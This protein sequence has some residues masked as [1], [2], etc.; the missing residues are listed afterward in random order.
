MK[1]YEISN[2]YVEKL[3]NLSDNDDDAIHEQMDSIA[4]QFAD[5]AHEIGKIIR[6]WESDV[7]E[8]RDEI[9]RLQRKRAA[10][11]NR[12][13]SL[14]DYL[15]FNMERTGT[16]IIDNNAITI[17]VHQSPPSLNILNP[18]NVPL[19]Y[20]KIETKVDKAGLKQAIQNGEIDDY[21]QYCQL[22]HSKN[23]QIK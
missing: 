22:E 23:V 10:K 8:L 18:N 17:K 6:N 9:S 4:D 2:E 11:E 21:H 19:D 13:Q 7:K 3:K 16:D 15:L 12:I 5:K 20:K 1:L 14:K